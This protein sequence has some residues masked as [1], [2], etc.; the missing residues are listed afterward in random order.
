MTQHINVTAGDV[1]YVTAI[2][3][4]QHGKPL[5][6]TTWEVG[7]GGYDDTERPTTW[8]AANLVEPVL[9]SDPQV[10]HVSMLID[11]SILDD[12]G[13]PP[14]AGRYLWVRPSDAP[15]KRA[16]CVRSE[17]IDII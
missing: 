5:T 15:T 17:R 2:V 7:L 14:D 9:D 10:V 12:D 1:D 8:R 6:G 3:T 4:E 16:Y 11:S 13:N